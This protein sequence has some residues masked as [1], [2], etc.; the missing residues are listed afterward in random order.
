MKI[1]LTSCAILFFS[2]VNSQDGLPDPSFGAGG[3]VYT[4]REIDIRVYMAVQ[5]DKKILLAGTQFD[6]NGNSDFIV[7]RYLENGVADNSFNGNGSRIINFGNFEDIATCIAIQSDGKILIGGYSSFSTSVHNYSFSMVRLNPDGSLDNSFNGTGKVVTTFRT[8]DAHLFSIILQPDGKIVAGGDI[9]KS[10][11]NTD[12]DFVLARYKPNGS[13]D[14]SFGINGWL[15][16]NLYANDRLFSLAL[17]QDGK[18]VG[19]GG[20][21]SGTALHFATIRYHPDGLIDNAF[22]GNGFVVT[23]LTQFPEVARSVII[24]QDG[25]IVISGISDRADLTGSKMA[26]IRYLPNGIQDNSFGNNGVVTSIPGITYNDFRAAPIQQGD[27]IL[28]IGS[29]VTNN[30]ECSYV[31][32]RLKNNGSVDSSFGINGR[33]IVPV[34]TS[35]FATSSALQGPKILIAGS[36]SN[37]N[38]EGFTIVRLNSPGRNTANTDKEIILYPNPAEKSFQIKSKG[39][40]ENIMISIYDVLGRKLEEKQFSLNDT[41]SRTLKIDHLPAAM[42]FIAFETSD[43]TITKRLIKQ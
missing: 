19:A 39:Y 4:Y 12:F 20:S 24:Q 30:G 37:S 33:T 29:S 6:G 26:L 22:N 3:K 2:I 18:I 13:P 43:G 7:L 15:N 32:T 31:C 35:C 11:A 38:G 1:L 8:Y 27:K 36:S 42:Y 25:K 14:S 41:Q 16:T 23:T 28:L 5:Q 21:S 34:G 17:Q 40:N 9:D 10:N